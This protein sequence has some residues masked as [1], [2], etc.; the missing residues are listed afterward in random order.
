M[1]K[2][3]LETIKER[4]AKATPVFIV[5]LTAAYIL[6]AVI[7]QTLEMIAY[8]EVRDNWIDTTMA[9]LVSVVIAILW[10]GADKNGD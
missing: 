8:G 1:N 4:V 5:R 2:E 9:L 7:W 6:I 3:Q 10:K